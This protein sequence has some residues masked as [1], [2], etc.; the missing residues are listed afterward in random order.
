M[1]GKVYA[2][3]HWAYFDIDCFTDA[4]KCGRAIDNEFFCDI[5]IE[6]THDGEQ[7][8]LLA[9]TPIVVEGLKRISLFIKSLVEEHG[10][11]YDWGE[12]TLDSQPSQ[13][14]QDLL[15]SALQGLHS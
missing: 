4:R 9:H 13:E 6:P 1:E 15:V 5:D 14:E 12:F 2:Y 11:T 3:T 10:G 8:L 7:I